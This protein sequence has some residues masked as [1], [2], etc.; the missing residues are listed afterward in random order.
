[1]KMLWEKKAQ[2]EAEGEAS[3]SSVEKKE[4]KEKKKKKKKYEKQV[5]YGSPLDPEAF[6]VEAAN[7]RAE[8]AKNT[9]YR[10]LKALLTSPRSR[11]RVDP[12]KYLYFLHN[13]G[14]HA[15]SA[16]TITNVSKSHIAFKFRTTAPHY[17][18]MRPN[19]GILR[20]NESINAI[21]SKYVEK[22]EPIKDQER[23]TKDKF[24]II[25]LP[26]E[27][28]AEYYPDL[29]EDDEDNV[30]VERLLRV[31]F[32]DPTKA[33]AEQVSML[34]SRLEVA[35][36]ADAARKKAFAEEMEEREKE[37]EKE[38]DGVPQII[39][40]G[41]VQEGQ[42]QVLNEWKKQRE[43]FLAKQQA[44]GAKPS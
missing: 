24:K 27:P 34:Q 38:E 28:N 9:L 11:L 10:D 15:N 37:R 20:P 23:K 13:A 39:A 32:V 1:M 44:G 12:Q 6:A 3:A 21:V 35:E 31:V 17:C 4:R 43:A 40:P 33:P 2:A 22:H 26:V 5:W 25:S 42:G 41:P 30:V 14:R 7:F 8:V 29:F 16:V 36:A 18:Y 19:G